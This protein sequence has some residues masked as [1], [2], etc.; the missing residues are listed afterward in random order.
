MKQVR[1][2]R[3]MIENGCGGG[4]GGGSSCDCLTT[5]TFAI[6]C[7]GKGHALSLACVW[8]NMM[9]GLVQLG[10]SDASSILLLSKR[11]KP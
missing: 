7:Q 4:G 11:G 6:R 3:G 8:F 5:D 9:S 10:T 2:H 1:V